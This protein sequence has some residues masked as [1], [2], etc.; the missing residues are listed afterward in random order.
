MSGVADS[1]SKLATSRD[2]ANAL[3][4]KKK[5]NAPQTLYRQGE[6]EKKSDGTLTLSISSED[7]YLRY[8]WWNDEE[9]FEV[10]SHRAE[11]MDLS[12]L[13]GGAALLYNHSRDIHLGTISQ[14]KIENKR[15]YVQARLS[16]APDCESFRVRIKEGILKDT[17]VGYTLTGDAEKIG[18]KDG[19]P[20]YKFNWQP[21]EASLV[22]VAAD[23]SVGIGRERDH[24]PS[25]EPKEIMV[26]V[27]ENNLDAAPKEANT[28]N[29]AMNLQ[30]SARP[31]FREKDDGGSATAGGSPPPTVDEKKVRAE[32]I[33][34]ERERQKKIQ[35]FVINLKS[36]HGRDCSEIAQKYLTGEHADSSFD[37][38]R[39]EVLETSFKAAPVTQGNGRPSIEVIGERREKLLTLGQQFVNSKEVKEKGQLRGQRSMGMDLDFG[40]LGI[41]GKVA[42][43]QR[44]GFTSSDLSAINITVASGIV[45]LG[46]QRLTIMDVLASGTIGTGA[47][48]YAR[49]N[50]FGTINGVAVV[51]GSMPRAQAV[52]ERGLKPS[53]EPDLTTETANVS[54]VAI[55]TKVPDE[56]LTDFPS[57]MSYIDE[58]MPFMVDTETEF[59]ILYGD[60]LN[61]NL[62]GIFSTTGVQTRAVV[63]TSD[64]TV[65]KSLRQGLTDIQVNAQ[66][67]PDFYGFHPY[68]WETA[69]L[70]VDTAGRFL[71]GGPF[72]IP[73]TNGMFVELRTFWGKPVVVSTAI[74]YGRPICGCGKLGAQ[75]LMREGMRI[76]MTNSNEDDFRRNLMCLRAEHR[77]A[78]PVYRPV[79]FLEFTAFPARAA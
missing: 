47:Y 52:G 74:T 20:I 34:A 18:E 69:S 3:Q 68:D 65:A 61:N 25:G 60:G 31:P 46:V 10:L 78:L 4:M 35:D 9:Y 58:R 30:S 2:R 62:K 67:E 14:P 24:K 45:T 23:P 26:E 32:A 57:A 66:F 37:D 56:F 55:T 5:L 43:S 28:E 49:E 75:V 21:F 7:P 11:D 12:R 6:V 29:K 13:K 59:Q 70:L 42:L 71:A 19:K 33:K 79:S 72:Y 48:K 54:K 51:A 36:L 40:L 16:E 64:T 50:G 1:Q 63:V 44:A 17:S 73:Y 76:E 15:C 22:T 8:D 38:F 39:Q 27:A 53:W 41:K 77:L